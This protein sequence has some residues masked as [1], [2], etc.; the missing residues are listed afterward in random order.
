MYDVLVT[1]VEV[2]DEFYHSVTMSLLFLAPLLNPVVYVVCN[3]R[4]RLYI[5]STLR[6]LCCKSNCSRSNKVH[7]TTI[8]ENNSA[9]VGVSTITTTVW[10]YTSHFIQ[11]ENHIIIITL[12][13]ISYWTAK[14]VDGRKCYIELALL[15]FEHVFHRYLLIQGAKR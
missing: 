7:I 12:Y 4:Y 6:R 1:N 11:L 15:W 8:T 2:Q 10:Q 13:W 5:T 3:K 9:I 14:N